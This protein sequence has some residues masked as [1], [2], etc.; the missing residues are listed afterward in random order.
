MS[1]NTNLA[2]RPNK[3]TAK[4]KLVLKMF[5]FVG[6]FSL[7]LPLSISW[8]Q[9]VSPPKGP[10][11]IIPTQDALPPD[12]ETAIKAAPKT[13]DVFSVNGDAPFAGQILKTGIITFQPNSRLVITNFNYPYVVILADK[14]Q[15]VDSTSNNQIVAEN[16][17][18][19]T[20]YVT[21]PQPPAQGKSPKPGS[22]CSH[23]GGDGPAGANGRPGFAGHNG[24]NA[25]QIPKIYL[26]TN[27]LVDELGRPLPEALHL[28]FIVNGLDG[29][30]AADGGQGGD[31]GIGGDGAD[32][33]YNTAFLNPHCNCGARSGGTGGIGGQGGA[34]G[35]GGSAGS[36]GDLVWIA[37]ED[38]INSL[39]YSPIQHRPGVPGNGG[40]SGNSGASGDGGARG[41]HPGT[42][43]GG[44]PGAMPDTPQTP[45]TT[46]RSGN[47]GRD[48]LI[49]A[50]IDNN[51]ERLF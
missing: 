23:G 5:L 3:K 21:P 15:F 24:D 46:S 36:G 26:I 27:G 10:D 22:D 51:I 8:A 48:G 20:T 11:T 44:L 13:E 39:T 29:G 7:T 35:V 41:A 9:P 1:Q 43:E 47:I 30:N 14:I 31:A 16:G 40:D 2:S 38:V 45:F 4:N 25:P 6:V 17:W 37:P 28:S 19:P 42:C 12:V 50:Q 18:L 49:N 32:G 33:S 34:G